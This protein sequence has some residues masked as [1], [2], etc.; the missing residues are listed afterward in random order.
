IPSYMT[1]ASALYYHSVVDQMPNRIIVFNAK[2]SSRMDV[3]VRDGL[4][5]ITL[6]K[7]LPDK[8]FGFERER[9]GNGFAYVA[10]PEKAV[11]DAMYIPEYCPKT[12]IDDALAS[13]KL[14]IGLLGKYALRMGSKAL[15][16][17]LG[18]AM[19]RNG[20]KMGVDA[21]AR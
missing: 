15:L 9:S 5:D 11:I 2:I 13:K 17:R 3:K 6:V 19:S 8:I 4:Y 18:A 7:T 14:D 12:Y 21:N 16:K 20:L 10:L 1:M